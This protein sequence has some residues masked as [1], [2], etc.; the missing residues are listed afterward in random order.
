MISY[1]TRSQPR[2]Y[3]LNFD[4]QLIFIL[5]GCGEDNVVP[6]DTDPTPIQTG[7]PTPTNQLPRAWITAHGNSISGQMVTLAAETRVCID[8]ALLQAS[9]DSQNFSV[10]VNSCPVSG[11]VSY[12][13]ANNTITNMPV[14]PLSPYTIYAAKVSLNARRDSSTGWANAFRV[15]AWARFLDGNRVLSIFR[16]YL[17]GNK[18]LIQVSVF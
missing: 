14:I 3:Y 1:N 5:S 10:S 8:K 4:F 16:K 7:V 13:S 18:S 9:V 6:S 12:D 15:A 11:V 2:L 17:P